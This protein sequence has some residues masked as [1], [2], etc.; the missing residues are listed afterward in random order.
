MSR[1]IP[2]VDLQKFTQGSEAERQ[3]FVQELGHALNL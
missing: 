1:A 3:E 2:L